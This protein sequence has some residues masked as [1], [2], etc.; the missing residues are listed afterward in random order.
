MPGQNCGAGGVV[1]VEDHQLAEDS[2]TKFL[3]TSKIPNARRFGCGEPKCSRYLSGYDY[4]PA[5]CR[6][7]KGFVM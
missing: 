3:Q 1:E 7:K 6:L 5:E 4:H 2:P